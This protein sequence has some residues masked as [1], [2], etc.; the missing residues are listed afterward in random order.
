MAIARLRWPVLRAV[1]GPK[2]AYYAAR[3]E[4]RIAYRDTFGCWPGDDDP[5][6]PTRSGRPD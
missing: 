2:D 5:R 3:R 1:F 6:S 4:Y